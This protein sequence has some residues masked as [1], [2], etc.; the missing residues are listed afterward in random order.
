[1]LVVGRRVWMTLMRRCSCR[2]TKGYTSSGM[3]EAR[4]MEWFNHQ[5]ENGVFSSAREEQRIRQAS[6]VASAR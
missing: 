6:N 3:L 5:R 1:M 2:G 4:C